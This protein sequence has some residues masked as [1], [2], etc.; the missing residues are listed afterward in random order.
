[1]VFF[2]CIDIDR[3]FVKK[4]SPNNIDSY[5]FLSSITDHNSIILSINLNLGDCVKNSYDCIVNKLLSVIDL[6]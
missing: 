3:F 6:N 1:M 5:V 4:I 2:S